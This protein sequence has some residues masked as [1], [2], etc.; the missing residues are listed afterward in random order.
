MNMMVSFMN[1]YRRK[2]ITKE[3]M[4]NYCKGKENKKSSI[5][6]DLESLYQDIRLGSEPR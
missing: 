6:D 4:E 3:K 2:L 5:N 1:M